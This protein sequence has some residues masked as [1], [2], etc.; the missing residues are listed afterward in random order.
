MLSI[1]NDRRARLAVLFVAAHQTSCGPVLDYYL[2]MLVV[3]YL[4]Q[5]VSLIGSAVLFIYLFIY[6]LGGVLFLLLL[7]FV[8]LLVCL[9]L[10]FILQAGIFFMLYVHRYRKAY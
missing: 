5:I 4:G 7:L 1:N 3:P 10:V 8:C 6:L 9:F 2:V